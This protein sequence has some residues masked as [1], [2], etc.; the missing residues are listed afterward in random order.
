M[1][2]RTKNLNQSHLPH[3]P[4]SEE[5]RKKRGGELTNN[6]RSLKPQQCTHTHPP[7]T[8]RSLPRHIHIIRRRRNQ[9][10]WEIQECVG[11]CDVVRLGIVAKVP[12]REPYASGYYERRNVRFCDHRREDTH[13]ERGINR[14]EHERMPYMKTRKSESRLELEDYPA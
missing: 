3:N 9:W 6:P 1:H 4:P 13:F 14:L 8:P 10:V 12:G 5:K 2:T 11:N 7:L